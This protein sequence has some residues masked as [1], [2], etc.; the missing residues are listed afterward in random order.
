MKKIKRLPIGISTFATIR[1]GEYVY[2]DKTQQIHTLIA[3]GRYYFLSRPRRFGKSLL[4]STLREL[5][6]GNKELFNGLQIAKEGLYDFPKHP[7][8]RLAGGDG[9]RGLWH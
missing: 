6:L 1:T 3:E 2:A 4:I 8:L 7:V 9:Y 5:F